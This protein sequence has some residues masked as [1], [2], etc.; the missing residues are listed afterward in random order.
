MMVIFEMFIFA[1]IFTLYYH[2]WMRKH[3]YGPP[4]VN[5]EDEGPID[6]ETESVEIKESQTNQEEKEKENEAEKEFET[7]A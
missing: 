3:D 4:F 5:V 7:L 2:Q 1:S 6:Q